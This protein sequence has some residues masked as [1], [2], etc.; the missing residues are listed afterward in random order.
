MTVL[1][2]LPMLTFLLVCFIL[3]SYIKRIIPNKKLRKEFKR[4]NEFIIAL[5][6]LF[7][8]LFLLQNEVFFLRYSIISYADLQILAPLAILKIA[9]FI[10]AG[11]NFDLFHQKLKSV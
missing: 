4:Q 5:A 7:I 3:N 1:L 2:G 10:F 11:L 8:P 9:A 6:Y